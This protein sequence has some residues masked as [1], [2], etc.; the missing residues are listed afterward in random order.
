MKALDMLRRKPVPWLLLLLVLINLSLYSP[1]LGFDFLKDDHV[2]VEN[3]PRVKNGA[4]FINTFG[5]RF[6]AFPDFPFL[7]YW[8]PLTL[9]SYRLDYL[10]WK[11][12]PRGFHLTNVLLNAAVAGLVFLFFL[13]W[14]GRP[15]PAFFIGLW[16]SLFPLHA[17]NV[18]WIS[19]RPDLLAAL[20]VLLSALAFLRY[21]DSG[22]PV[23]LVAVFC[24][25]IPGLLVKE[26]IVVFPLIALVMTWWR[27]HWRRGRLPVAGLA[28]V[29]VAFALIH[30]AVSGSGG[31]LARAAF[32]QVPVVL[33][34]LGVYTR[35]I[36]VPLFPDPYFTMAQFDARTLEWLAWALLAVVLLVVAVR[37]KSNWPYLGGAMGFLCVLLPV[38]NPFLVPSSPPVATRFLYLP[39]VIGGALLVDLGLR[40]GRK[41][42]LILLIA[43]LV[44]TGALAVV[45]LTYQEYFRDD[46]VF[47]S[48]LIPHH[49]NDGLLLLPLALKRAGEKRYA[50][51]LALLRE[52]FRQ[53]SESRW[54]D[55][56][57]MSALLEANLLLVTGDPEAGFRQAKRILRQTTQDG[58]RFKVL[59]IMAKYHQLRGDLQRG[60]AALDR[61]EELGQ[62]A[63]LFLQRCLMLARAGLWAQA[64]TAMTR[65]R[66][67]NPDLTDYPRL[68]RLLR[69][70]GQPEAGESSPQPAPVGRGE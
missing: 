8:R 27:N 10:I 55:V 54:V 70:R 13:A 35:M 38:M 7:H 6:F 40:L 3:N 41:R 62:T 67:L 45:N 26:N 48:R 49:P 9:L 36:L 65:A 4:V 47:F 28:V 21:L 32:S 18:A 58:T 20:I 51:A 11:E 16:F 42:R 5:K 39:A 37:R 59:L 66:R 69:R 24:F 44:M 23:F 53:E 31:M 61:A 50:E 68:L 63:E 43:V 22:R 56:R 57:E 12:D 29:S 30:A 60:L 15:V 34:T 46:E 64:E 33:S 14:G 52:G 17:E 2:L 25:F 1:T 19:G